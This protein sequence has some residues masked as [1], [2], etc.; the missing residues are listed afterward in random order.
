[1]LESVRMPRPSQQVD[2]YPHELSGGQAQRVVLARALAVNPEALILDEPVS[3]LDVSI[4][5]QVMVLLNVLR[6]ELDLTYLLI[7]HDLAVVEQL[8]SEVVVMKG[9]RVVEQGGRDVVFRSPKAEYTRTLLNA[10]PR[11]SH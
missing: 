5:A 2:A 6:D 3:A 11:L 4:Q 8:C 7:S 9:G 10:A 1:M